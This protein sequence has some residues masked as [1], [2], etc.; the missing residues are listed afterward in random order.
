[1]TRWLLRAAAIT[2]GWAT[3]A[4][5]QTLSPAALAGGRTTPA[6]A[7]RAAAP[8]EPA[9]VLLMRT[10]GQPDRKLKILK[11]ST[12]PDG[13]ALV[14]VQEVTTGQRFTLPAK[15]ADRLPRAG[16]APAVAAADTPPQPKLYPPPPVPQPPAYVPPA[17]TTVAAA[18]TAPPA[19]TAPPP[20]SVPPPRPQPTPPPA[21]TVTPVAAPTTPTPVLIPSAVP[22]WKAIEPAS[23]STTPV[24]M[25]TAPV[26]QPVPS[27]AVQ[28]AFAPTSPL[29]PLTPPVSP[30]D[31]W[32]PIQPA[33][34]P[35]TKPPGEGDMVI[36]GQM[37]TAPDTP[38]DHMRIPKALLDLPRVPDDETRPIAA[39]PTPPAET[40]YARI[41]VP[42]PVESPPALAF[43]G[44]QQAGW[45]QP[46]PT[47]VME[48]TRAEENL[49]RVVMHELRP[50]EEELATALRPSVRM[51]VA[52][53]M[54][55]MRYAAQPEVKAVLARSAMTDPS[56]AVRTAC[57]RALAQLGYSEAEYVTYLQVTAGGETPDTL[58]LAAVE[59]LRRLQP[60]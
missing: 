24:A 50:L 15:L 49:R 26:L 36:R 54:A 46:R 51:N 12:F 38:A 3:A 34:P 2:T 20:A 40:G 16:A 43:A 32:K 22:E 39:L 28:P 27:P 42:S 5:A 45:T 10:A 33:T 18:P 44:T 6:P 53:N 35:A 4:S 41:V 23:P 47:V 8:E 56:T 30:D 57:V 37:P 58:R 29:K 48:R 11:R 55:N 14:D 52:R 21:P 19:T 31:R 13:E 1:M 25:P 7:V 9:V 60:R 17:R 59:A